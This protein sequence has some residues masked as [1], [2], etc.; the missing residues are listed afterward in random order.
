MP[1]V[2]IVEEGANATVGR[3]NNLISDMKVLSYLVSLLG[4]SEK[5]V[6]RGG[7]CG[8]IACEAAPAREAQKHRQQ[9]QR[10]PRIHSASSSKGQVV[11]P[12]PPITYLSHF[13]IHG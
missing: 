13:P 3:A 6:A 5:P 2:Y 9:T 12:T 4:S 10:R 1:R 11:P 8:V 7:R